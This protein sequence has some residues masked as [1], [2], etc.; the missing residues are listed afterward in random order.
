M[1]AYQHTLKLSKLEIHTPGKRPTAKPGACSVAGQKAPLRPPPPPKT[2]SS[3]VLRGLA[4]A[5][6]PHAPGVLRCRSHHADHA[7]PRS[8]GRSVSDLRPGARELPSF[9]QRALLFPRPSGSRIPCN[10]RRSVTQKQERSYLPARSSPRR[11]TSPA[12]PA[13]ARTQVEHRICGC[14]GGW[15]AACLL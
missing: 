6:K 2:A 13:G 7:W 3:F 1:P 15:Q 8:L 4:A 10:F 5:P 11:R 12:A 14:R 9:L